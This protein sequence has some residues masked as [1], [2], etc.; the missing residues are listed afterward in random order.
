MQKIGVQR[1]GKFWSSTLSLWTYFGIQRFGMLFQ[2][3]DFTQVKK[4]C[5]NFKKKL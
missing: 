1:F 3:F 2:L 4:S 5:K